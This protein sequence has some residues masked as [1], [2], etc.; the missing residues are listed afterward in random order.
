V[1]A[2][3]AIEQKQISILQ[4]IQFEDIARQQTQSP[5]SQDSQFQDN[6]IAQTSTSILQDKRFQDIAIDTKQ[7]SPMPDNMFP[8]NGPNCEQYKTVDSI[9]MLHYCSIDNN[10]P[11]SDIQLNNF[12]QASSKLSS[13]LLNLEYINDVTMLILQDDVDAANIFFS[14]RL[15]KPVYQST[16]WFQLRLTASVVMDQ[17]DMSHTYSKHINYNLAR[18]SDLDLLIHCEQL[19]L[20]RGDS[21]MIKTSRTI[22]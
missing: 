11:G 1:F 2:D 22:Q 17:Y 14:F 9:A 16:S 20:V 21:W 5:I 18:L 10:N 7:S 6:V 8:I 4:D 3:N 19:I 13:K 12:L 15:F